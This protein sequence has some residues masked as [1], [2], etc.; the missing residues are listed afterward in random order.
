MRATVVVREFEVARGV[1]TAFNKKSGTR[2]L[3][4]YGLNNAIVGWSTLVCLRRRR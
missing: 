3:T 1:P 2:V 4:S